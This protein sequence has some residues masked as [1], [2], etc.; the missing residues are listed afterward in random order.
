MRYF[1]IPPIILFLF[2]C[3]LFGCIYEDPENPKEPDEPDPPVDEGVY[4]TKLAF[5][6]LSDNFTDIFAEEI[7]NNPKMTTHSNAVYLYIFNKSTG[8]L[9]SEKTI[10]KSNL[11]NFQ[12]VTIS[13][14]PGEYEIRCWGNIGSQT[15]I[16]NREKL[17]TARLINAKN[18]PNKGSAISDDPLYFGSTTLTVPEDGF[19]PNSITDTIYFKTAHL[20]MTLAF[21]GKTKMVPKVEIRNLISI[22]NFEMRNMDSNASYFPE[23]KTVNESGRS[24][25]KAELNILR[26]TYRQGTTNY[27]LTNN[28]EILVKDPVVDT[29]ITSVNLGSWMRSKGVTISPQ[30]D[31]NIL[32]VPDSLSASTPGITSFPTIQ[33]Q[34]PDTVPTVDPPPVIPDPDEQGLFFYLKNNN[35]DIFSKEINSV[36][37]YVYEKQSGKLISVGQNVLSYDELKKFQ[38]F[39]FVVPP[40][41]SV[42]TTSMEYEIR[43]WANI[44]G[45]TLVRSENNLSIASLTHIKAFNNEIISTNDNLYFGQASV[46]VTSGYTYVTENIDFKMAHT[47][48]LVTVKGMTEDHEIKVSGLPF[49]FDFNMNNQQVSSK[50][51]YPKALGSTSQSS[52]NLNTLRLTNQNKDNVKIALLNSKGSTIHEVSLKDKNIRIDDNTNYNYINIKGTPTNRIVITIDVGNTISDDIWH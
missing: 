50:N 12:G 25:V 34:L 6:C 41:N 31:N 8:E 2:F 36:N 7:T 13:L 24:L 38:G 26:T 43:C 5:E 15:T 35:N 48:F 40:I 21:N 22:Y 19:E 52:F 44:G 27:D 16:Y 42:D 37:I 1:T 46:K 29:L 11:R 3:F 33:I 18:Y 9:V 45:N 28:I 30:K 51:Y 23:V 47:Q 4:E 17:S 14:D 39:R 10:S 20:Q 32:S 49:S